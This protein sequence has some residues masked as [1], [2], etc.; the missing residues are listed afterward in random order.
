MLQMYRVTW[1]PP[2]VMLPAMFSIHLFPISEK[3]VFKFRYQIAY[4]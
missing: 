1:H 2:L 3:H 4:Q